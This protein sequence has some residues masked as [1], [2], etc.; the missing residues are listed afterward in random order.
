MDYLKSISCIG[1]I[2][3]AIADARLLANQ[4][5]NLFELLTVDVSIAVEVEHSEGNFKMTARSCNKQTK[6]NNNLNNI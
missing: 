4:V 2:S 6:T 3:V 1:M 5:G